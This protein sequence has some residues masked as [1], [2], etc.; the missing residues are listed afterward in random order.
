M[1]PRTP[2]TPAGLRSTG[3]ATSSACCS[4]AAA[5]TSTSPSASSGPAAR[6]GAAEPGPA[7]GNPPPVRRMAGMQ[8]SVA[9]APASELE[10][11]LEQYRAELTAYCYRM[12]ASPFDAE[13]AVQ[14]TMIRAW[15][16]I[17]RF[18]MLTGRERRAR[19]MDLGPSS[20]P[21]EANLNVP[22]EVT[23]IQPIP[24]PLVGSPEADPAEVTASRETIRLAFVAALQHLPP[25]QRAVLILCEVLRWKASEVAELLETSV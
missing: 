22:A 19:P 21:I 3:K 20:Q 7:V 17:D 6:C 8:R 25:R 24:D 14:E 5:R 1:R 12:L 16:G 2:G 10:A 13:D 11:Q 15:R 9:A 4:P 18:D 23:W